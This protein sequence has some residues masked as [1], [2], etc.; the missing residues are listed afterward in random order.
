M[1]SVRQKPKNV[2][3]LLSHKAFNDIVHELTE[4]INLVSSLMFMFWIFRILSNYKVSP[5]TALYD[6]IQQLNGKVNA[7]NKLKSHLLYLS[8]ILLMCIIFILVSNYDDETHSRTGS[9]VT[10]FDNYLRLAGRGCYLLFAS[11]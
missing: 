6:Y 9:Y 5:G 2:K 3:F 11:H 10:Y 8:V 1:F 7:V 4:I